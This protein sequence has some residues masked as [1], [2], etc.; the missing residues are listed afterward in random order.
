MQGLDDIASYC[1][2]S[3]QFG[4]VG[5]QERFAM[6]KSRVPWDVKL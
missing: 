5:Y 6:G 2:I 3:A 1:R 4:R